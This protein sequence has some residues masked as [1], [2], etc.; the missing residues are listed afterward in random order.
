MRDI[1]II[2]FKSWKKQ[3]SNQFELL[4]N[5]WK[6]GV[7][8]PCDLYLVIYAAYN[9]PSSREVIPDRL[10]CNKQNKKLPLNLCSWSGDQQQLP[11]ATWVPFFVVKLSLLLLSLSWNPAHAGLRTFFHS[12]RTSARTMGYGLSQMQLFSLYML[13][14]FVLS[15]FFWTWRRF[16]LCILQ[17][18][19]FS[20]AVTWMRIHKVGEK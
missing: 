9:Y 5:Q 16:A 18:L 20:L 14:D 3:I 7:L 11:T 17:A 4:S 19:Y 2:F 6:H 13:S 1:R 10:T 12:S 8:F 15:N